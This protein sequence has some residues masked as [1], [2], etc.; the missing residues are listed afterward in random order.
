MYLSK[1]KKS[2]CGYCSKKML[3]N[4]LK[5]H[6]KEVHEK[7]KLVKGQKTLNFGTTQEEPQKKA[8]SD[9]GENQSSTYSPVQVEE[10]ANSVNTLNI[11]SISKSENSTKSVASSSETSSADENRRKLDMVLSEMSKLNSKLSEKIKP[12]K[13]ANELPKSDEHSDKLINQLNHCKTIGDL[14][15]SF[16]Y[17]SYIS[18]EESL[19]CN[20]CVI[21]PSQGGSHSPGYFTHNIKNDDICKSTKVLLRDFRNLK[22]H[23]KCHFEN[24]V[25]LKNDCDLQKK[26]NS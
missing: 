8:K 13:Q 6:C 16:D 9:N 18:Q 25:H 4:N 15:E 24:E 20:I 14:C 26:G 23:V 1:T 11:E 5:Q 19:V 21:Y 22:S 7:I 10:S 12:R 2:K 3:D 17:L